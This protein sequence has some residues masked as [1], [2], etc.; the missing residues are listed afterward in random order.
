MTGLGT[1]SVRVGE[2][3]IEVSILTLNSRGREVQVRLPE[4]LRAAELWL[5]EQIAEAI[6]RGRCEIRVVLTARPQLATDID[7]EAVE[8]WGRVLA[9]LRPLGWIEPRVTLRDLLALPGVQR[10]RKVTSESAQELEDA[11]QR[12]FAS[13][14]EQLLE[15]RKAEGDK[16]S[17][18]LRAIWRRVRAI[19]SELDARA[20]ELESEL[21]QAF[22]ERFERLTAGMVGEEDRW[23]S[24]LALWA[25]RSSVREE[26][27]RIELHLAK[28]EEVMGGADPCGRRIEFLAQELLREFHTLGA[29][30]PRA[31][32]VHQTL[33]ARNLC[34]QLREQAANVE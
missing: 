25:A 11:I 3:E 31:D 7:L 12:A 1:A 8:A 32:A 30:L 24:E 21:Q 15:A 22:R 20:D 29:K 18:K 4:D 14:L 5:R 10:H 16:L 33:E 6:V 28:L 19:Y 9:E 13:A 34:E 23:R 2:W 27:D 17:E 26:L